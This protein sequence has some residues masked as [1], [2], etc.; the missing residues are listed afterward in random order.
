MG[1]TSAIAAQTV[2]VSLPTRF[3][4]RELVDFLVRRDI[5]ASW[6]GVGTRL[7][8][9]DFLAGFG[10]D[11]QP[12]GAAVPTGNDFAVVVDDEPET[13]AVRES[14]WQ[15]GVFRLSAI[16]QDDG[17]ERE[18]SL[19]VSPGLDGTSYI[20]LKESG[21]VDDDAIRASLQVWQ[22]ALNR[23]QNRL[24]AAE[25]ARRNVRQAIVVI[26]GIGE[27]RPGQTSR[28]FTSTVFQDLIEGRDQPVVYSKP[29]YLSPLFDMRIY[30]AAGDADSGRPPTDVYELYWAHLIRDT[31][32]GQVIGWV[33]RLFLAS[34][35][36]IPPALMKHV[37]GLRILLLTLLIAGLL[38]W[39]SGVASAGVSALSA[40]GLLAAA[41]VVAK[42][43]WQFARDNILISSVGDAT[44]YLEPTP[45]NI[46]RRQEIRRAGVDLLD[47]LHD[48]DAYSRIIMV[49]HSLGSVIAYDI[50]SAAWIRRGRSTVSSEPMS[51]KAIVA[52]EDLLN[53]REASAEQP[54]QATIRDRQHAAWRE[55]RDNGFSWLVSDFV[56]AGSPLANA[57]LLLDLDKETSFDDLIA[58][59]TLPTCPPQVERRRSPKPD[60]DRKVFTFTHPYQDPIFPTRTR[61]VQVP[62]HAGLFALT[63]WSNLYFPLSGVL[64]GDPVGGTLQPTFGDW[65]DDIGL[66]NP[67]PGLFGFAHT[68]YWTRCGTNEHVE[69]LIDT[70]DLPYR[71]TLSELSPRHR[72]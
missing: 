21:L 53:P 32:L 25:R 36:R 12:F 61:S 23:L 49:G 1:E 35:K 17:Q 34:N 71:M 9:R 27:Q 22:A 45:D 19:T 39:R 70:L 37:W 72:K 47:R 42:L 26:H 62:H 5:A 54:T 66:L 60:V 33:V 44:R 31:T 56:T 58:N 46:Q 55:Y 52:L 65:I 4:P 48:G 28:N 11:V 57:R 20:R 15:G 14:R 30:R 63:R 68:L 6:L 64:G 43:L 2:R 16:A 69:R 40:V 50:L 10:A 67:K 38:L 41:G 51:S 8:Q 18:F 3:P 7:P 59:R 13:W 24:T 29:D